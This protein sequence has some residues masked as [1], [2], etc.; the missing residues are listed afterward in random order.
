MM[1]SRE[2][3]CDDVLFAR[4]AAHASADARSRAAESVWTTFID[5]VLPAHATVEF[6]AVR[7][8]I[9]PDTG[10]TILFP[11]LEPLTDRV[12]VLSLDVTW[13]DLEELVRVLDETLD[14]DDPSHDD[15]VRAKVNEV[16]EVLRRTARDV[17][18]PRAT[19]VRYLEWGEELL[20]SDVVKAT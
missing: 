16:V 8:E 5:Q 15:Q 10:R 20:A 4:V 19:E 13:E 9:W 18:W 14:E 11:A 12:D 1:W 17:H 6:D 7:V 3:G 2:D